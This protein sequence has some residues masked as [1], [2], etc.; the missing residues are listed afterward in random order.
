MIVL[1]DNDVRILKYVFSNIPDLG[2]KI[3]NHTI[4]ITVKEVREV[5]IKMGVDY[6]ALNLHT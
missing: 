6:K 3:K 4:P 1:N 5:C 2:V